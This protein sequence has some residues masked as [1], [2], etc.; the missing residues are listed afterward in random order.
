MPLPKVDALVDRVLRGEEGAWQQLWLVLEPLVFAMLRRPRFLG[1]LAQ[2]E[3]DCRN[4]VVEVL[5]ALREDDNARLRRFVVARET[6]HSWSSGR[7]WT[8]VVKRMAID[9]MRRH[10]EYVDRQLGRRFRAGRG[11][12]DRD[13]LARVG[14]AGRGAPAGHQPRHR[15]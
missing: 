14:R 13:H 3:D 2:R 10:G 11:L 9:Y 8:V 1:R 15:A 6:V 12:A 4:I 5:A 7:G